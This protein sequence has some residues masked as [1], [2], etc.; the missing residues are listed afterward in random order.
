M[1]TEK[2]AGSTDNSQKSDIRSAVPPFEKPGDKIGHFKLLQQIGEGGCGVVYMAEQQEPVKRRVALKVIKPG[3]DT[4]QVLARF[5]AER[6]ALALMDHPNIA[7]VLDAGATENG[8]PFFVMELVRGVK[9]TDFC[10][11]PQNTLSTEQ[12]LYLFIEICN[13]IQH[14]HQ[15]GIIHRDIKPSNILV[16]LQEDGKPAPKIIDF[17]IAKATAGQTLTDKTLFTAFEQFIGTPAY[18]SPEQAQLTAVDIDTRSDIYSLGVLL[19]ELLT[20]QTPFDAKRLL[21]AGFD[22]IRRIIVQEEPPRPSTRLSSLSGEEKTTV[23]RRRQSDAPK[24]I[25]QFRGDLDW[26]AMKCLD[27]NRTRRY[28]TASGLAADIR[29]YLNHEPVLAGPP[30][31]SYRLGKF[32]RKHRAAVATAACF[33]MLL[34]V[35]TAVSCWLAIRASQ[36]AAAEAKAKAEAQAVLGFFQDRVLAAAR[37]LGQ[38]GGLG[39]DVTVQAAIRTADPA[40]AAAFSNQ[41]LA[42]ASVRLVVGLTYRYL[43]DF[44][45]AITQDEKSISLRTM[46]LGKGHPDTLKAMNNIIVDYVSGGQVS[47]G[48]AIGEETTRL[49]QAQNHPDRFKAM[50]NLARAYRAAGRYP[51]ALALYETTLGLMKSNLGT[52]HPD[53]LQAMNNLANA[54]QVSGR[55]NDSIALCEEALKL[56]KMT[57]GP[58]HPDTLQ[59]MNNLAAAYRSV[60]R[61]N[62]ALPLFEETLRLRKTRLGL[63]HYDTLISMLNLG[64]MYDELDRV[65]EALALLEEAVRLMKARLGA[66]HQDTLTAMLNLGTVYKRVRRLTEAIA[67]QKDTL[68]VMQAVQPPDHPNTLACMLNLAN[69]YNEGGQVKEALPLYEKTVSLMTTKLGPTHQS[70]VQSMSFLAELLATCNDPQIR[71]G[72]RAVNLAEAAVAATKRKNPDFLD[73]LA[74]AYAENREFTKAISAEGEAIALVKDSSDKK[75]FE[76]RLKLYETNVPYRAPSQ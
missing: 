49:M 56:R 55:L 54:Y 11:D 36:K 62:D 1:V 12:R 47:N 3:M 15:K 74:A 61:S 58:D 24:L 22:E 37:P 10:D 46:S 57:L 31:A 41:P 4:R 30:T 50:N 53:T 51:E 48:I 72:A 19:Y 27:K 42:E 66:T 60:G 29:R 20:G 25:H 21:K 67:L 75:E 26:I 34:A 16:T 63:E 73:T 13:A 5:E 9:I 6:Q 45:N 69:T 18:M 23:A 7:K 35:A 64:I 17:G 14:A 65:N 2:H 39:P 44:T 40:I 32:V 28:E 76:E 59:S 38:G 33:V 8:R 68:K 71:D 70:T 43:S 52:N